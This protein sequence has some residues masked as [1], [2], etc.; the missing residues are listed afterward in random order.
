MDI[1]FLVR[2]SHSLLRPMFQYHRGRAGEGKRPALL[3][4]EAEARAR[5]LLLRMLTPLQREEFE[6]HG[7]FT[8]EVPG[9]GTFVVLPSTMFNVLH[10]ATG[11]C[12]C[13]VP[14]VDV[15]LSDL[16]LCQKLLL[17]NDPWRFFQVANRRREL[18][19]DLVDERLLPEQ[20]LR[21]R[22]RPGRSRVRWS[23][24]SMLPYQDHAP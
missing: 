10:V 9:R 15:P 5:A 18:I 1:R 19:T 23:E 17:E 22:G 13:A 20:V 7:Y 16:M 6:G 12:Y 14:T 2:L 3:P 8:V 11:D 4:S 24:I 21:A